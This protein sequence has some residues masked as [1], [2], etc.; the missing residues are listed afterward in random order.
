[1]IKDLSGQRFGRLVVLKIHPERTSGGGARWTCLCDCGNEKV[2]SA[3]NIG[4]NTKSCG[5]IRNTQ[6]SM[7]RKHPLWIRWNGMIERCELKGSKNYPRYGGRGIKV[8]ERWHSFQFFLEDMETTFFAGASL[9]RF[10]NNDGNYEPTNVRWATP[11][12]QNH[13]RRCSR[14]IQTPWGTMNVAEAA[15]RLGM[16]REMFSVRVELGWSMDQLFD[17]KNN[18][19]LTKWDR[20]KGARNA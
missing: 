12:Q 14:N 5:C 8:C 9:D 20:R 6:N 16:T 1:M 18:K 13:N 3:P 15:R 2:V 19:R 11:A 17:P 4:R 7:T 10:P